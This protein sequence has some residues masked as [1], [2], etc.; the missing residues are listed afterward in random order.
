MAENRNGSFAFG[1]ALLC[2]SGAELTHADVPGV[3][4]AELLLTFPARLGSIALQDSSAFTP[5]NN[6]EVMSANE[7]H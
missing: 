3:Q 7:A 2:V 4:A 5:V 1:S 6:L